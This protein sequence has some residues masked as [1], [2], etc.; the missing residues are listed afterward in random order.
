MSSVAKPKRVLHFAL[1]G[2][3]G[4]IESFL[5]GVERNLDRKV[6]SCDYVS[7]VDHPPFE[8][9]FR[10]N[11]ARI[12][13]IS[14][15]TN[16]QKYIR[17]I[18][19]ILEEA[20]YDC[21]HIHKNTAMDFI[22]FFCAKQHGI[23]TIIGHS[24]NTDPGLRGAKRFVHNIGKRVIEVTATHKLACSTVA[25][26]WLFLPKSNVTI[27]NNGIHL[28]LLSF[29]EKSRADIREAMGVGQ[30][31][32]IGNV[33]RL[34]EQKNQ[35]FLIDSMS[36]IVRV[37]PDAKLVILGEGPLRTNLEE[38]VRALNLEDNVVLAGNVSNINEYLSAFDVLAMPSLFEGFP[39]AAIEAQANG[40]P[41]VLSDHITKESLLNSNSQ[42]IGLREGPGYWAHVLIDAA[43]QEHPCSISEATLSYDIRETVAK[44]TQIY[45]T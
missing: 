42:M 34:T 33:G 29:N 12:Y 35:S 13:T 7:L 17:Q 26:N 43:G 31:L 11:G 1:D 2:S 36:N 37:R 27:I 6:I 3:I 28:S 45:C 20:E 40:L 32:L 15:R 19:R 44:L 38:K 4:G 39:I 22:P 30:S 25:G 41:C 21:V 18:S 9:E 5:I 23:K 10:E 24:H 8:D 16:P 14:E